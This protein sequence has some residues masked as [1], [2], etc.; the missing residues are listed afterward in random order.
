MLNIVTFKWRPEPGYRSTFG[1]DAVNVLR[2]MV[3]RHYDAPHRFWCITDDPAGIDAG[4]DVVPL[5]GD[6][7]DLPNPSGAH[8]NPSCY[9]RLR[10]FA[11]DVPEWLGERIVMLDLDCVV[12]GD[13]RPLWDRP[14]PFVAWRN[15][16][17]KSLY[18]CSMLLFTAGAHPELWEGFGPKA[19][20][21]AYRAGRFGSDQGWISH[22]LGPGKPTWSQR[23]GVYSYRVDIRP[24]G[25]RLPADSR[26]VF[27][28]GHHD[29]WD[30]DMQR[31][32]WIRRHYRREAPCT[33]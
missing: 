10:L 22:R 24:H 8:R 7:A 5:W 13:L 16:N 18:N 4:I 33:A 15:T 21:E 12:T 32:D 26:I 25:N 14:E 28:H 6:Y 20:Q 23:D 27:F 19:A 17:H 9:R 3:A 1:A 30:D 29:P 2:D 31:I 11:R